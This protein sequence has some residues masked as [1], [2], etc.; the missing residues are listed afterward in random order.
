MTSPDRPESTDT[1]TDAA[2]DEHTV[3]SRPVGASEPAAPG[4][5]NGRTAATPP[6]GAAPTGAAPAEPAAPATPTAEP[7]VAGSAGTGSAGAGSAG[8]PKATTTAEG[9]EV[10]SSAPPPW[11][12]VA[13]DARYV[14]DHPTVQTNQPT[15]PEA[16]G[17]PTPRFEDWGYHRSP[18]SDAYPPGT[19][20]ADGAGEYPPVVT[21]TAAASMF[22][23]AAGQSSV[24]AGAR[25]GGEPG[26]R[27]TVNFG[28]PPPQSP[29]VRPAT[30]APTALRRPGR[31]PRRASLQVK[32]VDPWSVLKLAFVLSVALF[33]VWLVAVG[34]LYGV[35]DGMGVW[36]RVNGTFNE[37]SQGSG[38]TS[39]SGPLITASRVFGIAAIIGAINI[40]LFTALATVGSFVYNVSA[41]LAG[42]LEITLAERE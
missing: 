22:A 40:V 2:A 35:L 28:G 30:A 42:G 21:G 7:A 8:A 34:V 25:P 23:G 29:T 16:A 37:F 11:Q 32:R 15:H 19:N 39:N 33:F 38:T 12:R 4:E 3:I 10:T 26:S 9:A 1:T 36:D 41:D 6:A 14:D 20:P 24:A 17:D 5:A 27:T 13:S 31:G 18:R